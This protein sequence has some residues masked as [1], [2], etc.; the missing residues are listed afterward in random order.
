MCR[1]RHY[2][3]VIEQLLGLLR[4]G[5]GYQQVSHL[6]MGICLYIITFGGRDSKILGGTPICSSMSRQFMMYEAIPRFLSLYLLTN[7]QS[8]STGFQKVSVSLQLVVVET[9]WGDT[10]TDACSIFARV[11]FIRTV[12]CTEHGE[13]V[14]QTD[15][16]SFYTTS[17]HVVTLPCAV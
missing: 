16:G 11:F 17:S 6:E 10:R 13:Q 12:S 15:F 5:Y 2:L 14:N 7:R 8:Q 9:F 1:W 3:V 4:R